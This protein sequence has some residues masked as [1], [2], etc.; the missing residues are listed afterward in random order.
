MGLLH[1]HFS[2]VQMNGS[3][4]SSQDTGHYSQRA[5][6]IVLWKKSKPTQ[7]LDFIGS[8]PKKKSQFIAR[9]VYCESV[10]SDDLNHKYT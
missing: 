5:P 2:L 1:T 7:G 10:T 3:Q 8:V 9:N 6:G 4:I